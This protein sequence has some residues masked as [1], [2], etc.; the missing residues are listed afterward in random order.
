MKVTAGPI[1]FAGMRVSETVPDGTRVTFMGGGPS[2]GF[3]RIAEPHLA[4]TR[5]TVRSGTRPEHASSQG[6]RVGERSQWV[7]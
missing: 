2:G 5:A 1:K 4:F 6:P 7:R 3:L